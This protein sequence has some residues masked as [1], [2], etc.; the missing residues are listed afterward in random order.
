MPESPMEPMNLWRT[1]MIVR[2]YYAL[3]GLTQ[4]FAPFNL[5]CFLYT[6][7]PPTQTP[8]VFFDSN[9]DATTIES[10][11]FGKQHQ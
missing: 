2:S 10:K 11:S 1:A 3:E 4:L 7:A 8:V 9:V 6:L 5:L